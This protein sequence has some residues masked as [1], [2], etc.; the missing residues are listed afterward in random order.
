MSHF[1][2]DVQRDLFPV[3]QFQKMFQPQALEEPA[4][5]SNPSVFLV[6]PGLQQRNRSQFCVDVPGTGQWNTERHRRSRGHD[7]SLVQSRR[8]GGTR[9]GG[10]R[11]TRLSDQGTGQVHHGSRNDLLG[12]HCIL[13]QA[14]D[15]LRTGQVYRALA[16]LVLQERIRTMRQQQ[17]A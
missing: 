9:C 6:Q 10:D 7:H 16:L 14:S 4:D 17:C 5:I 3:E 2:K 15:V 12:G 13:E 1:R 11:G 8:S